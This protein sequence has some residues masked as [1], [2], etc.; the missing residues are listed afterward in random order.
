LEAVGASWDARLSPIISPV[1]ASSSLF[2]MG[3]GKFCI[4]DVL[5]QTEGVGKAGDVFSAIV[6]SGPKCSECWFWDVAG[7]RL[8]V[9]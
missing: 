8:S 7:D 3:G 6:V 1:R 4:G 9:E 2:S 5:S